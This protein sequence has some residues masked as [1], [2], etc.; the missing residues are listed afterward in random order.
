MYS[1]IHDEL[2]LIWNCHRLI[3]DDDFC[4]SI[5]DIFEF[6]GF[7]SISIYV[8]YVLIVFAADSQPIWSDIQRP[9]GHILSHYQ[10]KYHGIHSSNSSEEFEW[11]RVYIYIVISNIQTSQWKSHDI[12]SLSLSLTLLNSLDQRQHQ[13]F[14]NSNWKNTFLYCTHKNKI[15]T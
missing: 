12:P 14:E 3:Y 7:V 13:I 4:Y 8:V 9:F 1:C 15:K 11:M 5:I 2:C 6:I 10:C